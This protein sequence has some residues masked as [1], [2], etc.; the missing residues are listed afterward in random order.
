MKFGKPYTAAFWESMT[1]TWPYMNSLKI[2]D[3]G[4]PPF[5]KPFLAITQQPIVRLQRNF[6]WG[7]SCSQNFGSWTDTG[8]RRSTELFC[9]TIVMQFGLRWAASFVSSPIHLLRNSQARYGVSVDTVVWDQATVATWNKC[10]TLQSI[11]HSIYRHPTS[12][13][14]TPAQ[15][16]LSEIHVRA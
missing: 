14:W 2:Q 5:Q 11:L 13:L 12:L 10:N 7:N 4:P 15:R 6:A 16:S 1:A 9:V 3:G 8:V